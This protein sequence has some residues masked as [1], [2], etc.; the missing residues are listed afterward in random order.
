MMPF[1]QILH[2]ARM[3]IIYRVAK[4]LQQYWRVIDIQLNNLKLL[5]R[6]ILD[7]ILQA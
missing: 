6:T 5:N 2:Q 3:A 1:Y 7:R 4:H